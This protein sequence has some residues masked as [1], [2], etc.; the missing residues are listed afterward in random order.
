MPHLS[1]PTTHYFPSLLPPHRR[2]PW[3]TMPP[4]SVA[5]RTK[6]Q[7]E[8]FEARGLSI[9]TSLD[10]I[11]ALRLKWVVPRRQISLSIC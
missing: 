9:S 1:L 8:N 10:E 11:E 6:L 5:N 2:L 4:E 7:R 3:Q